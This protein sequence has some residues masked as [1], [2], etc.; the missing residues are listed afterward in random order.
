[1]TYDDFVLAS[2]VKIDGTLSLERIFA[3]PHLEF[4]LMLSSVVNIVGASG[5][6]NYNAGNSV[7]DSL[8]QARRWQGAKCQY[9]SLNVGWIEDA[10]HT[11]NDNARLK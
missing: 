2:R 6:A 5:Q 8:A 9:M 3:S 1:M 7:L 10:V 11:V 4:F